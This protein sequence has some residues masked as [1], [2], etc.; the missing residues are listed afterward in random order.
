MS[1]NLYSVYIEIK[2]N[3]PFENCISFNTRSVLFFY[4][5]TSIDQGHIVLG[6]SVCQFVCLYLKTFTLPIAFE[7]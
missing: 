3:V 1:N 2:I 6:Q 7:W 4:A 5:P